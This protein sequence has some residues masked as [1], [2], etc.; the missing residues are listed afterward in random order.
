MEDI[1]MLMREGLNATEQ[2]VHEGDRLKDLGK[3]LLESVD[4][5]KTTQESNGGQEREMRPERALPERREE[6][7]D[8]E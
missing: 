4:K 2:T 1:F 3:V 6:D 5:F 7:R 8:A